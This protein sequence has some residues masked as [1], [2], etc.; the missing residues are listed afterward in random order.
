MSQENQGNNSAA[1]PSVLPVK[2]GRG[3]PRKYDNPSE[4]EEAR[5]RRRRRTDSAARADSVLVG[6]IVSGVLDGSFDAGY[7][8]TVRVGETDT[9]LRG[10]VFKPGLSVPVSAAND[11]APHAKMFTR[12]GVP[13]PAAQQQNPVPVLIPPSEI[14]NG[15]PMR[16]LPRNVPAFPSEL[17]M[18]HV[19]GTQRMDDSSHSMKGPFK[20]ANHVNQVPAQ[21]LQPEIKTEILSPRHAGRQDDAD[22][23]RLV[24]HRTD[25]PQVEKG[26]STNMSPKKET[27]E[28]AAGKTNQL[29]LIAPQKGM[30]DLMVST[31]GPSDDVSWAPSVAA[32]AL[33]LEPKT[34]KPVEV[35]Q[36]TEASYQTKGPL[37]GA[38]VPKRLKEKKRKAF[39]MDG[40][41]DGSH[42]APLVAVQD[43]H[44]QLP[45]QT[46][47]KD[48]ISHST[49]VTREDLQSGSK[50]DRQLETLVGEAIPFELRDL[51]SGLRQEALGTQAS[52]NPTGLAQKENPASK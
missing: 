14:N 26:K 51:Q 37:N 45:G 19:V 17:H 41:A 29:L 20:D 4:R 34:E 8:L 43:K 6:Q 30:L 10:I 31:D 27:T 13:L 28:G 47:K 49:K 40:P 46:P 16:I 1:T 50:T 24:S 38:A 3:R 9:V 48:R 52:T 25:Q 35:L 42:Q 21:V 12:S 36:G 32:Q 44:T 11:V 33:P 15:G 7:L 23:A 5:R 22:R 39:S 18:V 2:R